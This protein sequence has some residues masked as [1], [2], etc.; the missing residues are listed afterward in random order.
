M[1]KTLAAV[2]WRGKNAGEQKQWQPLKADS[3]PYPLGEPHWLHLTAAKEAGPSFCTASIVQ[4][5]ERHPFQL[6]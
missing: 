2:A 5:A 6:Q 1:S 3:L 4:N